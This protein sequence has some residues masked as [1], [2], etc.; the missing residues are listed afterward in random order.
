[1]IVIELKFPAGRWHATAWGTHV[2]EGVTEWPPSPWRLCRALWATW[3]HKHQASI[4]ESEVR[5]IIEIL[6]DCPPPRF[7][8]PNVVS[9]HTRHYMP[10]IEGKKES[11]T[12]IFDTF[13]QI[14][15]V[16]GKDRLLIEWDVELEPTQ[17]DHLN[18]LLCSMSYLGRA[19]SLVEA[20]LLQ[21]D[22]APIQVNA[23]P[24]Y[25]EGVDNDAQT[26]KLLA[27]LP[28]NEF[29]RWRKG[30]V[31]TQT[32]STGKKAKKVSIPTK[33]SDCLLVD[34]AEWKKAQWNQPP[35]SRWITYS[36]PK[37]SFQVAPQRL[38]RI[39]TADKP[40]VARFAIDSYVRPDITQALSLGER[41]HRALV[42]IS[43]GSP[44][45]SG[46]DANENPLK[47]HRH[48]Y[49]FSE[50]EGIRGEIRYL[51]VYA[52]MGFNADD[53]AALE[54]LRK[55]W[56]YDSRKLNI[57][58]VSIGD[59]KRSEH[60]IEL[61]GK[62]KVW[63]SITPFVPTRHPKTSRNGKP[64]M[65]SSGIQLGSHEHDLLRLLALGNPNVPRP[66]IQQIPGP[67]LERKLVWL[68][69]QRFR[70][71]GKGAHAHTNGYGYRLTF[72]E[73][74]SGPISLGYGAHF[75]LGLFVPVED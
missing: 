57:T 6:I 44:V 46:C 66:I 27:P 17:R 13:V 34:T 15:K 32:Q 53:R 69:Y 62:S 25:S 42:K 16:A 3:F 21:L 8:L 31:D 26:I 23:A 1:M 50:P 59:P 28:Q 49:Y 39:D 52:P 20:K 60:P 22:T 75:G 47:G 9:A 65:D 56:D 11:K 36:R 24:I 30:L 14:S 55:V 35:G 45:F 18:A 10:S 19:E 70:K 48:A 33:V 43:D 2:N 51:T 73:L 74:V 71:H 72:P 61:F 54:S 58:L 40:T 4:Q 63:E 5:K 68:N 12:K 64:R 7:Q 67:A 38:K 37:Q 41:V 29:A